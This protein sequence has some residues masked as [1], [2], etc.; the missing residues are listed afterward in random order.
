MPNHEYRVA[1]VKDFVGAN[2]EDVKY[3]YADTKEEAVDIM[4]KMSR[5]GKYQSEQ[6]GNLPG[7]Q[8]VA[9]L[10]RWNDDEQDWLSVI[11]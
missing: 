11:D 1:F 10:E 6:G 3:V 4:E 7:L 9:V 8:N 5:E 2:P